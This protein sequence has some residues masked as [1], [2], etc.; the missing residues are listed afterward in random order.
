VQLIAVVDVLGFSNI[1][2]KNPENPEIP[3]TILRHFKEMLKDLPPQLSVYTKEV[4]NLIKIRFFSDLIVYTIK[5][6]K[7]DSEKAMDRIYWVFWFLIHSQIYLIKKGIVIRGAL[8]IGD[9]YDKE[10]YI[11]GPGFNTAYMYER[12]KAKH[13]VI[14]LSHEL[15]EYIQSQK[16]IY[17]NYNEITSNI[18]NNKQKYDLFYLHYFQHKHLGRC[19]KD[20]LLFVKKHKKKIEEGLHNCDHDIIEKYIWLLSYHNLGVYTWS[21][22]TKNINNLIISL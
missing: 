17:A 2:N 7:D 16:H 18:Q 11:Y 9:I 3:R 10:E 5:I 1:V 15:V 13:P 14:V 21:P 20:Y 6:N 19:E 22:N 12:Y 4:F 8:H